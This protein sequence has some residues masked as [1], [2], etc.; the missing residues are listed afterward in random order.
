[1]T[2]IFISGVTGRIGRIL[3][4]KIIQ[5]PDL[6][7]AGGSASA[8]SK[9][10]GIDLGVLNGMDLQNIL[11]TSGIESIKGID[12]IVDFSIPSSSINILRI[13]SQN[14]I[15]LLIGTTG[16]NE[17]QIEEISELSLKLPLLLASNTSLGIAII[18]KIVEGFGVELSLFSTPS[19]H[20]THHA[21]KKDSPS[22]TALDLS[23]KLASTGLYDQDIKISS[24]REGSHAGEHK[25][26]F[27]RDKE[28]IEITH[29]ALDR[30]IFADGALVGINWLKD[31]K[32][33]LYTMNDIY[34][35]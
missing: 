33:G 3:L 24:E 12:C 31:K 17:N 30:S 1:M 4:N 29:K 10:I 25:I 6:S 7:L 28:T 5:D 22:G 16:F 2:S 32:P 21:D 19:I 23:L 27:V 34:S 11:I 8:A 15:P 35:S 18:K 20:E 26:L 14:S 9:H 13:A